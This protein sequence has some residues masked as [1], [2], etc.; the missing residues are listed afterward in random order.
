M[1]RLKTKPKD[2]FAVSVSEVK[3]AIMIGAFPSDVPRSLQRMVVNKR[4][5]L[6][7][8]ILFRKVTNRETG[9][10]EEHPIL[11]DQYFVSLAQSPPVIMNMG[12]IREQ[13]DIVTDGEET[14]N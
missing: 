1:Y 3:D 2:Y 4:I 14:K 11:D 8:G 7:D 13:F 9:K 5:Y 12:Q 6:K 10:K